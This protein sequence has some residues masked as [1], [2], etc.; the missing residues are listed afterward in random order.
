MGLA[1][2][3]ANLWNDLSFSL[4]VVPSNCHMVATLDKEKKSEIEV[5]NDRYVTIKHWRLSLIR[6]IF[7]D[8]QTSELQCNY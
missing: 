3:Y 2:R 6:I 1:W 8:Y 5:S 4:C 7:I